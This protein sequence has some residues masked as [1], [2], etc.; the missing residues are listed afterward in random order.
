MVTEKAGKH[1]PQLLGGV[2]A[3]HPHVVSSGAVGIGTER[4]D[5]MHDFEVKT[6]A[7]GMENK[8]DGFGHLPLDGHWPLLTSHVGQMWQTFDDDPIL[9]TP[10]A[11][12]IVKLGIGGKLRIGLELKSHVA[13][14]QVGHAVLMVT[15]LLLH[16]SQL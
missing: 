9:L 3:V 7:I 10:V 2:D 5:H 4:I 15:N 8:L 6:G 13:V 16:L 1:F 12:P 14:L 11:G